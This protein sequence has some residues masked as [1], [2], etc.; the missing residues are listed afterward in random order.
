MSCAK[1]P[2]QVASAAAGK[3]AT[4]AVQRYGAKQEGAKAQA[5]NRSVCRQVHAQPY[6]NAHASAERP[7]VQQG[8]APQCSELARQ[9]G[10]AAGSLPARAAGTHVKLDLAVYA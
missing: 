7:P 1:M 5:A 8:A 6:Q 10:A 9:R 4:V 3:P 2:N